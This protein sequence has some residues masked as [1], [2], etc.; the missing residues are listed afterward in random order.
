MNERNQIIM[1]FYLGIYVIIH[2]LLS[3]PLKE[4]RL[5]VFQLFLELIQ[6]N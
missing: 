1:H 4:K 6:G 2:P 3:R 5:Q